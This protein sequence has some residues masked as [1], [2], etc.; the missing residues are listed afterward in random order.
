MDL[1]NHPEFF[2]L[3]RDWWHIAASLA[4]LAAG[5]AVIAQ[6]AA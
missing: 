3:R 1:R 6:I 5:Y 4:W 2:N